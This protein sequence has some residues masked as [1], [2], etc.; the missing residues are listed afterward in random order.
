MSMVETEL[1]CPYCGKSSFLV[2]GKHVYPH[3]PD[4][5]WKKFYV[6]DPCDARVGCH[7]NTS[8]PMGYLANA[9]LRR[10]KMNAHRWF[11]R[12]WRQ[13]Y[14]ERKAAYKWLAHKMGM[15]EDEC[16]IGKFNPEQ[17]CKVVELAKEKL[18]SIGE[19]E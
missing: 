7:G 5:H 11:D 3:R 16:H 1:K 10:L 19:N 15:T 6:C 8:R 18:E 12:I 2:T 4:L 9:E 17:C 14:M 13:K